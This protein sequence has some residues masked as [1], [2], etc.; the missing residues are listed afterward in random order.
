MRSV[1][2]ITLGGAMA[3]LAA[4]IT[5]SLSAQ[6]PKQFEGAITFN[7]TAEGTTISMRQSFKGNRFRMDVEAPGMPGPL[8]MLGSLDGGTLQTVMPSMGMYMETS[9]DEVMRQIGSATELPT[10]KLSITPLGTTATIAG[11]ECRN[12]QIKRGNDT[13]E[14]CVA[15]GLGWIGN[16]NL[17]GPMGGTHGLPDFSAEMEEIRKQFP[18]GMMPLRLRS[19]INGA[20][21]MIMEATSI[22]VGPLDDA[23][24]TL[25]AGLRKMNLPG[26]G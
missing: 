24:F 17:P 1:T 12:F 23:L 18:K 19:N 7:I 22:E 3:L 21:T 20:M 13:T 5:T 26:D 16:L 25:P 4:P 2:L 10:G 15:E 6:S 8:F 11:T 14:I 9:T